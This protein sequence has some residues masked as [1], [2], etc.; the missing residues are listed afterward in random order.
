MSPVAVDTSSDDVEFLE[1]P[2][3]F[4]HMVDRPDGIQI[5]DAVKRAEAKIAAYKET[6]L[7]ATDDSIAQMQVICTRLKT[8]PNPEDER[9]I[10]LLANDVFASAG[11]FNQVELSEAAYSLCDLLGNRPDHV[12]LVWEAINVHIS[13]M[14]MLRQSSE[15][16]PE[17]RQALLA[18]L[19]QVTARITLDATQTH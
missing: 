8:A 12:P 2:N 10:Y 3:T 6:G 18:G 19:K 7:S 11:M 5:S 13:S 9:K 15:G 14:R 16:D 4:E 17:K 1:T